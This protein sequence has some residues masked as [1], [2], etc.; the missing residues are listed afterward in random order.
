VDLECNP[1][2][3]F[4]GSGDLVVNLIESTFIRFLARSLLSLGIGIFLH[5]LPA[6][7]ATPSP[8]P[9]RQETRWTMIDVSP[10]ETQ[11]DCHL[12]QFPDG[13]NVLIDIADAADAGSVAI[14]FLK[15]HNVTALDLVVISHFHKDHY[16]RLKDLIEAGIKVGRVAGNMPAPDASGCDAEM[17]WGFDR[18]H[19]E[20]T[21]QFLREHK[22]PYFRPKAG[23]RLLE[24]PLD[25]GQV[26]TLDV[27]CLYDGANT[28]VGKTDTNDTSIIVKLS[29]GTTRALFTGDLNN[30]L[31][32][33]LAHGPFDVTADL[34]KVPHHGT[35]GVAPNEFFA[36]VNPKAA[37]V[38]SPR[39]LWLSD[40]SKRIRNYFAD[41]KIPIYVSGINGN[42]TVIMTTQGFTIQAEHP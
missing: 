23:D 14:P 22:I 38:P 9:V 26:V 29:H 25:D 10:L 21:L 33:W 28:P 42:V 39:T 11:A 7:N 35:E 34:L 17:P 32:T 18:A 36:R 1:I 27:V 20:A 4:V 2:C 37:L 24:V 12:I 31:G 15:S 3:L 13:R 19:A 30:A 8:E 16:G 41:Q 5:G 40:R 6:A